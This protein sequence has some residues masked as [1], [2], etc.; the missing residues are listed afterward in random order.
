MDCKMDVQIEVKESRQEEEGK[1]NNLIIKSNKISPSR[2]GGRD[3]LSSVG[4]RI[5]YRLKSNA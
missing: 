4:Q 2:Q 5:T 3:S 1:I